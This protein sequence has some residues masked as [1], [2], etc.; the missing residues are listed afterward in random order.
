LDVGNPSNMERLRHLLPDFAEL[1][2]SVDAYPVDDDAIRAQIARDADRFDRV[3]CPHTA[4]GFW[5]YDHLPERQRTG[6]PWIVCATAHPAKFEAI[7]EAAVGRRVEVPPSLEALL[8]RPV[9]KVPLPASLDALRAKL[10]DW[11]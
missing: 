4:T 6:S 1:R 5:V 9:S 7:T 11:K 3:W 10:D 2:A 8:A